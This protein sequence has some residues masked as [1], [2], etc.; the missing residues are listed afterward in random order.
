MTAQQPITPEQVYAP[1][2][3]SEIVAEL[4]TGNPE[5]R[6]TLHELL[7]L[8]E[9]RAF[10]FLILVFALPNGIPAPIA[11]GLSAILGAPLL[12]LSGQLVFGFNH[13]WFP[14]KWL[15]R[16]FRRADVARLL[17]PSI[18]WLQ[19]IERWLKPRLERIAGWRAR[20]LIGVI[21]LWNAFLLSLPIPFGNLIPAWAIILA[22][23]GQIE[24]DGLLVLSSLAVSVLATGWVGLLIFGGIEIVS[25]LLGM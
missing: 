11:P 14:K 2:R 6:I 10:G 12:L 17:R 18:P 15:Q 8:F 9:V 4:C 3:I 16:S 20:R 25:H 7:E 1:R 19:K 13:P 22:A 5:D 21:V 24:R 23:L